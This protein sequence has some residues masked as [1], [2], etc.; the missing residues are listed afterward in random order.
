MVR[1]RLSNGMRVNHWWTDN[2]PCAAMIRIVAAGGRAAEG[3]EPGPSGS[4]AVSIGVRTLSESGT[5]GHWRREQVELFCISRLLNCMLETDEEF[6]FMDCQFAVGAFPPSAPSTPRL[7]WKP[8]IG[9]SQM[10]FNPRS[11][12]V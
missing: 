5:V 6:S 10:F 8:V 7:P 9:T 1:L 11:A 12:A 3:L 2:E 4:G